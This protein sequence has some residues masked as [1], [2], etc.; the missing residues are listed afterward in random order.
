MFILGGVHRDDGYMQS[1]SIK[2]LALHFFLFLLCFCSDITGTTVVLSL[3]NY[4]SPGFG[5]ASCLFI[6]HHNTPAPGNGLEVT[7]LP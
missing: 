4:T 7:V 2:D 1:N 3:F 6:A 5:D